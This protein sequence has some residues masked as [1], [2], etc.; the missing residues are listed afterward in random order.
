MA[1]KKLTRKTD[2]KSARYSA[3]PVA[4]K[5][6]A[7]KAEAVAVVAK[8]APAPVASGPSEAVTK[9]VEALRSSCA[10]TS[11]DAA[12]ALGKVGGASAVAALIEVVEN[13]DGY[14]HS[15][16]RAAACASLGQLR[17]RAATP[18]LLAAVSD[19]IAEPSAEAVRALALI[20]DERALATLTEVARNDGGFFLP[21]VQTAAVAALKQMQTACESH[22]GS[23]AG[24]K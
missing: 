7:A 23:C 17:D 20:G 24:T 2:R 4:K 21:F 19:P 9:L 5:P 1:A 18:A 22:R 16:V 10:D 13:R 8:A 14:F 3:T 11:R 6:D 12:V 15:V